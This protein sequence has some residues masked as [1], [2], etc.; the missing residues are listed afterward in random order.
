MARKS[1]ADILKRIREVIGAWQELA[2]GTVFYG[3]TLA[4]FQK[5]AH[6]SLQARAE[7]ED[8]QRRR[9]R[10]IRQR[11]AADARIMSLLRGV[12]NGVKGNP[13]HGE[14]GALY[15]TMGYVRKGARRKRRRKKK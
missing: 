6:P 3:L 4:Q 9:R 1:P 5:A 10:A 15:A 7:I 8:A 13:D 14:D 2:P 12:V 11:D